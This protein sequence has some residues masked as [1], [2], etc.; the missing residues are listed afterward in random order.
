[1][2]GAGQVVVGGVVA[3]R[4]LAGAK[5]RQTNLFLLV[6]LALW[7][8]ASGLTELFVSGMETARDIRDTPSAAVFT[9][10]RGRA[11][12]ALVGVSIVLVATF[13]IAFATRRLRHLVR[14]R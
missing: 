6:L 13:L 7:F 11:D 5:W 9:L 8:V 14:A 10:W 2:F 3:Y 1:M 12:A 4:L